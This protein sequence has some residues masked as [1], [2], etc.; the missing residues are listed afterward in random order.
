M[1]MI[2]EMFSPL[3]GQAQ[4]SDIDY[5][6]DLKFFIDNESEVLSRHMFPA[7]KKHLQHRNNPDA[8]K[9]YL[10]PVQKCAKI[11][12]EKFKVES[13]QEKITKEQLIV[14]AKQIAK[15]QDRHISRGDYDVD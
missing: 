8:Y 10:K 4:N 2:R 14:L 3:G 15:E 6:E 12:A 9:L 13:I 7:I 5:A 11:Y 1:V